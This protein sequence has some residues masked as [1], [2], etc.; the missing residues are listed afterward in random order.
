MEIAKIIAEYLKILIWPVVILIIV[1]M[2]RGQIISRFKDINELEFPGG[3]KAK[4]YMDNKRKAIT[5]EIV[6]EVAKIEEEVTESTIQKQELIQ[7]IITEKVSELEK[8]ENF[9]GNF[10]DNTMLVVTT[11]WS[12]EENK[13]Y[14]IYYDPVSRNHNTPFKYL[15]LYADW[16]V[17]AVGK[18]MKVASCN[19]NKETNQ[20]IGTNGFNVNSLTD[21]EKERIIGIIKDTG[22]YDLDYDNKFFLVDNF[23]TTCYVKQHSPIRAKK[24]VWLNK[25]PGF[26]P[27]MESK[28]VADLLNNKEWD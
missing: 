13:K 2:F 24:Y 20:L 3:F 4:L 10:A 18:V 5:E 11:N 28:D 7:N 9:T 21:S 14:N 6:S 22:Y 15:G 1:R 19:Y 23:Y 16:T 25:I 27:G 17:Y 8:S 12:Y 26:K